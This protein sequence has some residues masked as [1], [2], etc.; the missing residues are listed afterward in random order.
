MKRKLSQ[1]GFTLIEVMIALFVLL[2][3]LVGVASMATM[4]ITGNRFNNDLTMATTLAED[5]LEEMKQAGYAAITGGNDSQGIYNRVWTVTANTPETD[6]KR[7][8][9]TVSWSYRGLLRSMTLSTIMVD[10]S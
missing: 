1:Q 3:A 2:V 4:V 6:M 10:L 9:V 5:K 7:I 8:D